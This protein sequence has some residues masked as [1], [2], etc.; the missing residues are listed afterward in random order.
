MERK[1]IN[2]IFAG[3]ILSI[4]ILA[5]CGQGGLPEKFEE[6]AVK[7]KSMTA[8]TY[9]NERN[10]QGII[11]MGSREFQ[12][13]ITAEQ[14]AEVSDSYLDKCGD[15]VKMDKTV[16]LGNTNGQTG[17]T[18]GGVVMVGKY[19]SGQIQFTIAFNEQ[20]ELVQFI[21]R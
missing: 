17:E 10:Y 1:S 18:F 21:I 8:V 19:D 16:V 3:F 9:F 11:D 5:G 6:E 20:M 14:F 4:F 7:E 13:S 2:I 15:Y 12:E